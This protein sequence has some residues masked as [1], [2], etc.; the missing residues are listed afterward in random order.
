MGISS[1]PYIRLSWEMRLAS[2]MQV[3]TA[4]D[5]RVPLEQF[6]AQ[7]DTLLKHIT[8]PRNHGESLIAEAL[9]IVLAM[10]RLGWDHRDVLYAVFGDEA[11]RLVNAGDDSSQHRPRRT[12]AA[13]AKEIIDREYSDR[14]TVQGLAGRLRVS[15]NTLS[16][17]FAHEFLVPIPDYVTTVRMLA[18]VQRLRTSALS[19]RAVAAIV[20]CSYRKFYEHFERVIG[21]TPAQC[22]RKLNSMNC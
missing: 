17:D 14:I 18:A 20:G 10:R 8:T 9:L 16:R 2:T 3:L 6:R 13:R 7:A 12:I 11:M 4:I 22:R 1:Y 19:N 5:R 21:E 15:R